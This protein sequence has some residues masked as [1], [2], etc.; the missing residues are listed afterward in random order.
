MPLAADAPLYDLQ[1]YRDLQ[2][3]Q[4]VDRPVA[5]AVLAVMRRHTAYLRPET[6]VLS[7]ALGAVDADQRQAEL[8]QQTSSPNRRQPSPRT[9]CLESHM[10]LESHGDLVT[11]ASWL[12]LQL[13]QLNP[14]PGWNNP[15]VHVRMIT[16]T[17][18]SETSC[19]ISK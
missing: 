1:L 9:P 6:V 10:R 15:S 7:L 14:D 2:W 13:L 3:F 18:R 16:D 8:W 5:D 11:D 4:D 19:V 12:L 17:E